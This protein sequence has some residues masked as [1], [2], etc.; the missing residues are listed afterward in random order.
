MQSDD[1]QEEELNASTPEVYEK[2]RTCGE[3]T[4]KVLAKIVQ[5]AVPGTKLIDLCKLGDKSIEEGTAAVYNK[6][7]FERG[8]AFPTCVSVNNVAGHFSPL[9]GDN[10]AL[11][12][13]DLV[14]IDLG[15]HIDGYITQA[16]HSFVCSANKE[17]PATGRHADVICAA[18]FAAQATLRLFKAGKTNQEITATIQKIAD[19]FKVQPLEGVLSH[20]TKRFVIDGNNVV[21]NKETL[22]QK[23]EDVTFEDWDAYTFDI[24]MSTGE[25]KAKETEARTTIFKRAVDQRYTLKLKASRAVFTEINTR[26]P[27]MPFTLRALKDEKTARL[28]I[29][30]CL[31]HDLVEPYPVLSEKQGEL[32]AQIK[33]TAIITPSG[34]VRITNHAEPLVRSD[35]QITDPSVKSILASGTKK[36]AAAKKKKK[37]SKKAAPAPAAADAAGSEAAPAAEKKEESA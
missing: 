37:R 35:Y 12:E 25:G 18:Y 32:V 2:Y 26:F 11:N 9:T 6:S 1:I 22:E 16:G 23:V 3:I 20:Q 33:F 31:K 19:E 21:I 36:G 5:A 10:T 30:E 7:K 13:G 4:S 29:S 27:T 8:V 14:K 15:A 28:G 24:V 17:Q 34:T